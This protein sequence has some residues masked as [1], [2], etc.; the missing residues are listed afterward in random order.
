MSRPKPLAALAAVTAALAIAAPAA[1]AS[2]SASAA[3]PAPAVRTA[4]ARLGGGFAPG[5]FTCLFLVGQLR[6]AVATGNTPWV[7]FIAN[8][9]LYSGCG[10]AAI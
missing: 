5:S 1:S 2:A 4:H 8:V 7:N 9:L 6:F 3:T 10:G